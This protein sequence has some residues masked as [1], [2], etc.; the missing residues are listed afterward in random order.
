MQENNGP[1]HGQPNGQLIATLS[2]VPLFQTLSADELA[3]LSGG[4]RELPLAK[5]AFLFHKGDMPAGFYVVLAGQI[6]LLI[7]SAGGDEKVVEI[8]GPNG[9][10]GEAV[11]FLEQP[12]PVG[13]M[14]L[15]DSRLLQIRKD[16]V[17]QLL[18]ADP[19]F[20][21]RMLGGLSMRL[22]SLIQ[23]VESYSICSGIQRVIGYLLQQC[24]EDQESNITI[25]LPTSKFIIASRLNLTPETLSRVF[26]DLSESGLIEVQGRK[27]VV[28]SL[29]RLREFMG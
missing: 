11:M 4:V 2:R 15:L 1:N 18:L 22:R 19:R 12:C 29:K 10:F 24:P 28:P 5:G 8:I 27:I 21:R 3:A 7:S 25:A 17:D 26:H 13:A 14:A 16:T 6:K 23:D 20:A 9:T